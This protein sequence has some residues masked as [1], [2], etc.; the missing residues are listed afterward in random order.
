MRRGRDSNTR[1][2]VMGYTH[3]AG[4][5]FRPLSH[6]SKRDAY[7]SCVYLR[8]N[9]ILSLP[10]FVNFLLIIYRFETEYVLSWHNQAHSLIQKVKGCES[11]HNS[12]APLRVSPQFCGAK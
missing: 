5:R 8:V 11:L 7:I 10:I 3:L 2:P 9:I 4:E 6:L 1:Y 12:A